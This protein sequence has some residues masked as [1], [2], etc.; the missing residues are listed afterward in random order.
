MN[1][2]GC[3]YEEAKKGVHFPRNSNYHLSYDLPS[4]RMELA[5]LVYRVS[6]MAKLHAKGFSDG[7]GNLDCSQN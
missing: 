5:A 6:Y 4:F 1:A 3:S 7:L 2:L